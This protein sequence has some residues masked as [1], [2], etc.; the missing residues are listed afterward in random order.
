MRVDFIV[1]NLQLRAHGPASTHHHAPAARAARTPPVK[2]IKLLL[3]CSCD[4]LVVEQ[5]ILH[6]YSRSSKLGKNH[7]I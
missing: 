5:E 7:T 2:L 4:L 1:R 3:L 6:Q